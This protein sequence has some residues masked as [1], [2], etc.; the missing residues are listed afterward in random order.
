VTLILLRHGESEGNV[1][2]RIQ[3]WHD[4]PLTDRGHRQAALAAQ[5]LSTVPAVAL[6][7]SPLAR[8]RQTA[9]AVEAVTG[10]DAVELPA[11]REYCFGEAQG[12]TWDEA[13][14][15]WGFSDNDWGVGHVPGEEGMEAFR[16]RVSTL[17]EALAQRHEA[18]LAICVLHAGTLGA[19]VEHLCGLKPHDHAALYSGNCGI[20]VVEQI[21][22]RS[23]LVMLNDQ[24]HLIADQA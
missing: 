23:V 2:R 7:T 9:A 1:L 11:L 10:L 4:Y 14:A 12:M 17:F 13:A 6:Y 15:R 21:N 18:D 20:G 22:G 16:A 24:R 19:L 3:G 8:A 5:R